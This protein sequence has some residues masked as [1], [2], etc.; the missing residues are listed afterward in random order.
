ML[1]I[2]FDCAISFAQMRSRGV[3]VGFDLLHSS[4]FLFD[5]AYRHPVTLED[6][7]Y[8][9]DFVHFPVSVVWE[10]KFCRKSSSRGHDLCLF[11][12]MTVLITCN[13]TFTTI[14]SI[15]FWHQSSFSF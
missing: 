8:L 11:F 14:W 3:R 9:H 5:T 1:I 15:K 7:E 10:Y 4:Y 12:L 13:C 6:V 2:D